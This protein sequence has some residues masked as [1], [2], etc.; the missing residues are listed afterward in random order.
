MFEY[1]NPE[2]I[3]A[4]LPIVPNEIGHT[5]LDDWQ[6]FCSYTGCLPDNAWAKLAYVSAAAGQN[7]L[8]VRI[9]ELEE[10]AA[11]AAELIAKAV[12]KMKPKND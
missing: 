12:V 4:D 8:R 5:P 2:A 9:R 3:L 1:G 7:D 11:K 10:K 6:H